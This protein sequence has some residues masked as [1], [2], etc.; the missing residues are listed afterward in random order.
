MPN[1][2]WSNYGADLI[3]VHFIWVNACYFIIDINSESKIIRSY[4]LQKCQFLAK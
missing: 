1:Y 3:Y 4:H 2:Y